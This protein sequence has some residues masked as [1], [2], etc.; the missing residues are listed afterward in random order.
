MPP[1]AEESANTVD[2]LGAQLSEFCARNK[3]T[4]ATAESLTAGKL[5]AALGRAP[6]SGCWYRG[7]VVAY[8]PHVKYEVLKVPVGPVV[9][10]AAAH[11]MAH[12]VAHLMDADIAVSVTGEAGPRTQE[13]E[14][15]GTVW[16]GRYGDGRAATVRHQF[17]GAP[18]VILAAT[19]EQALRYLLEL[20]RG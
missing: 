18:E 2:A 12:E 11:A 13:D 4:V 3:L 9:C 19:V 1:S 7:G 14:P 10:S 5:A 16:F 20:A 8:S 17:E 15:P 6:G